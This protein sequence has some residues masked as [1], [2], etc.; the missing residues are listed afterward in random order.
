L[1]G[2]PAYEAPQGE[3][4]TALAALWAEVL[5]VP[6]VG[7]RDNFFELGGHS[8]LAVRLAA[9]VRAVLHRDLPL[10][11]I[12]SHPTVQQSALALQG[13]GTRASHES[14]WALGGTPVR[15]GEPVPLSY[16]Q[17]RLWFL[18]QLD[19]SDT[20]MNMPAA[21]RLEGD[22]DVARLSS[23]FHRLI[24]RHAALRTVFGETD[25]RGWQCIQPALP[26]P[27]P[28]VA[29]DEFTPE[30]PGRMDHHILQA[31][32]Q[33]FD[34]ARGPLLRVEL[35]RLAQ[36]QH[37]LV[38]V[39]HHI[40][41]DGWSSQLMLRD[42]ARYYTCPGD[43]QALALPEL[44]CQYADFAIAQ[45]RWLDDGEMQRQAGYWRDQLVGIPPLVIPP[46]KALPAQRKHPLGMAAFDLDEATTA[47][48]SAVARQHQATPFMVLFAC[49]SLALAE[50]SGQARF[51]V[52]TDMANRH[53]AD[54]ESVVGFFVN[55]LALPIDAET[56]RSAAELLS[57]LQRTVIA[58]SDHQDL[59]FD[60]LVGLLK[61]GERGGRA[62]LFQVKVIYRE[63]TE[64]WQLPGLAVSECLVPGAQAEL[65]LIVGFVHTGSQVQASIRYDADCFGEP[66]M[67]SLGQEITAVLRV[68]M[69]SS[70]A[71]L[72]SL[73][74]V[75]R[76][77]RVAQAARQADERSKKLATL[78]SGLRRRPVDAIPNSALNSEGSSA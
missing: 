33:P 9:R 63:A 45:R 38:V 42:L 66:S 22:L 64:A 49:A 52:G 36:R 68:L 15:E 58:A 6:R 31:V 18:W 74:Q 47:T 78:R 32:K 44:T 70:E 23:A 39:V 57:Q 75:A 28:V 16:A 30:T 72:D 37:M 50:R 61:A 17:Q 24:Q 2:S 59:P 4:E 19:P 10:Q 56:P 55:Q 7:R 14:Q 69:V 62:P 77:L 26:L 41:A 29:W 25:G 54:T 67:D 3:L 8:L 76:E 20:A 5:G 43:D 73:R 35:I 1:G 71:S 13:E 40:V 12:F 21:F 53:R 65:D 11:A 34:L 48:L 60:R 27:I 51:Y 46:E